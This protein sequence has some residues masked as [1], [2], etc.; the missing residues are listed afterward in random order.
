MQ[1][2]EQLLNALIDPE[3]LLRTYKCPLATLRSSGGDMLSDEE[4]RR[5][6][7]LPLW[8]KCDR[9]RYFPDCSHFSDKAQCWIDFDLQKNK[10]AN[11]DC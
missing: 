2:R 6:N 8:N 7:S 10:E 11:D 1:A 9:V 4:K 3:S 5:M